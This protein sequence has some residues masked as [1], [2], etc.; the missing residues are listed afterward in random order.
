MKQYIPI[1]AKDIPGWVVA[2]EGK[3]TV[4]LDVT[5][6]DELKSEGISRELINKIQNLRKENNLDVTDKISLNISSTQ[7]IESAL[8]TH[9]DYISNE[10]L[11]SEIN[12][13]PKEQTK[14]CI[15][16]EQSNDTYVSL[17]KT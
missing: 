11:A 3:L 12:F 4:A 7:A 8:N 6:T 15:D 9:R 17:I 14:H 10:V 13:V 2:S 1:N 5:I 16:I